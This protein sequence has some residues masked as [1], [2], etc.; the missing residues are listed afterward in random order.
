[1]RYVYSGEIVFWGKVRMY[2]HL[3]VLKDVRLLVQ[4]YDYEG[5][6]ISDHIAVNANGGSNSHS[7]LSG[8]SE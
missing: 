3:L 5:G 2:M 7:S 4:V 6:N 1:M 8:G